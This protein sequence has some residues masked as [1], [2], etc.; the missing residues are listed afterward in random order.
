GSGIESLQRPESG[1]L[2]SE[3][4]ASYVAHWSVRSPRDRERLIAYG[5]SADRIT[6]AA[7]VAWLIPPVSVDFGMQALQRHKLTGHRLVGVNVNAENPLVQREP[8]LFEK[9]AAVLDGLIDA[10]NVRV[11]FLCNEVREDETFDKAAA[12]AVKRHM[13]HKKEAF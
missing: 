8:K 5:V 2:V 4:L 3:A 12:T 13:R 10:H 7:D 11:V 6:T 9:L 1:L